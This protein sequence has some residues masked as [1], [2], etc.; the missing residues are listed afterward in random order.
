MK[1]TLFLL[2]SIVAILIF[3][4][5]WFGNVKRP[6]ALTSMAETA[7]NTN[8]PQ[9]KSALVAPAV[10]AETN[11][12]MDTNS[13][14]AKYKEYAAGKI[15]KAELEK[16]MIS[17][18]NAKSQDFYGQVIDQY[19]EP[20]VGANITGNLKFDFG[21]NAPE[22]TEVYKT[23]TDLTGLFQFTGLHG[24]QLGITVKKD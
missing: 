22:K 13:V 1:K 2:L 6:N 7:K 19:G 5:W 20:V 9:P 14:V 23:Q 21:F 15:D 10:K 17:E 4:L 12:P 11:S 3:S 24:W 16:A 18:G 8:S